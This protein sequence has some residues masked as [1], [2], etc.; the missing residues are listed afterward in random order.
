MNK[1]ADRIAGKVLF[2]LSILST[3]VTFS[4]AYLYYSADS[5]PNLFFR[6]MLILQNTIRAFGFKPNISLEKVIDLI[7]ASSSTAEIIIHYAYSVALFTAPYCTL[8]YLYKVI[9]KLF[10]LR[11]WKPFSS[12]ERILI[13][14][15]NDEVKS[16]INEYFDSAKGNRKEKDQKKY[17]I[18]LA[19]ENVSDEEDLRMLKDHVTVHNVN[20]LR[21]SDRQQQ[22]FLSQMKIRTAK[23]IIFFHESSALNFSLYKMFHSEDYSSLLSEDVKFF[24]RCED[25]EIHTVMEDFHDSREIPKDMETFSIP[26]FRIRKLLKS[27]PLHQYYLQKSPDQSGAQFSVP[28]A[29]CNLHLLI[30]GFGRLGQQLLLQTM[31]QGV[32]SST[33]KILVDV[34]DYKIEEK[35]S[36]FA[37]CFEESYVQIQ[38]DCISIPSGRADGTFQVRFHKMDIRYKQFYNF[39]QTYGS[40]AKGGLY[41]YAAVC[42][43]NEEVGIHCLSEIQRY[44]RNHAAAACSRQVPVVIRMEADKYMAEY[45]NNNDHSY[46]NVTVIPEGKKAV[47]LN[48]LLRN[49]LDQDAK[50]YNQIYKQIQIK[51]NSDVPSD[52]AALQNAEDPDSL[53]R[54]LKLFRRDSNRALSEHAVIKELVYSYLEKHKNITA[55]LDRAFG[56]DCE[57]LQGSGTVWTY[58]NGLDDFVEKQSSQTLYPCISE[59]SR[60]EHRRWCY[61]MASRGWRSTKDGEEALDRAT[62]D[63]HKTTP[64]LC[65][66]EDLV[67]RKKDTCAYDLIW[68]LHKYR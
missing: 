67:Q 50:K 66:W 47:V 17:R 56:M 68:L 15:Y 41:T 42:I 45:L 38:P 16:L 59:M 3:I 1:K 18:H 49:Q 2:S 29:E 64:C 58:K 48:E 24:C 37:N 27:T 22:H 53:W 52:P 12:K 32:V 25:N 9:R 5:C 11:S 60:M 8:S 57:L 19:A 31:N 30:I 61:F 62:L 44:L 6:C 65:T 35:Q 7:Q 40:D 10:Q 20:F 13:F 55:E 36:I 34:V 39:L 33:N 23:Y 4:E 26:E 46:P 51:A 28:P 14:G 54:T 63:L 21:L 43:E